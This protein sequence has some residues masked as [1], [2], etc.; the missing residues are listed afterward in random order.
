MRGTFRAMFQMIQRAIFI[1]VC[2]GS[3]NH[4][5]GLLRLCRAA[6]EGY[7]VLR[8]RTM[9]ETAFLFKRLPAPVQESSVGPRTVLSAVR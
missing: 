1:S 4:S 8:V 9:S 2:S 6:P 7:K 3:P 5:L